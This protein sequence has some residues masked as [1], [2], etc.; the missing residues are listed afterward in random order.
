MFDKEG[1][2]NIQNKI[3][4]ITYD[5]G[6]IIVQTKYTAISYAD[7]FNKFTDYEKITKN[8]ANFD[9]YLIKKP[10]KA[11]RLSMVMMDNQ[12]MDMIMNIAN[13]GMYNH[14]SHTMVSKINHIEWEDNNP[15][16]NK[17]S[18]IKNLKWQIIDAESNLE[19]MDI[20]WTFKKGDL[21]KVRIIN[22]FS[23]CALNAT[24]PSHSQAK[25]FSIIL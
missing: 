12:S 13:G 25:I 11:I 6:E 4:H 3:P 24:S 8:I 22:D 20:Q 18:T 5:L 10:D 2:F 17:T 14:H 7:F 1:K 16:I 19:N 15:L 21:I 9:Q 23:F